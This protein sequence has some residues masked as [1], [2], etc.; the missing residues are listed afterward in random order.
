MEDVRNNSNKDVVLVLVGNKCDL[1]QERMVNRNDAL[2][3]SRDF[4]MLYLETSAKSQENVERAFCWPASNIL[5]KIEGGFIKID[6][7]NPAIKV[8]KSNRQQG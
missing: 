2:K 1:A 6:D 3:L 7:S 8:S 4:D 5:D